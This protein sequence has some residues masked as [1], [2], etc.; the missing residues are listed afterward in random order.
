[1]ATTEEKIA[2]IEKI[3]NDAKTIDADDLANQATDRLKVLKIQLEQEQEHTI[4][5][6]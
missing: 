4:A 2:V 6:V 5:N 3:I 1:M